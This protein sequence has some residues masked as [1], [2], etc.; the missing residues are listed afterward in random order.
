MRS[1]VLV[2]FAALLLLGGCD[3]EGACELHDEDNVC[4]GDGDCLLAYCGVNCCPCELAIS[5]RQFDGTYCL[6]SVTEG[7]AIA[8]DRCQE[9][10]DLSC[11]GFSCTGANPCPHPTRAVCED[12]HCH[13]Q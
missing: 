2:C 12:G 5:Q 7:F 10:R 11:E 6:A 1:L 3:R 8:R 4:S 13:A 9:A